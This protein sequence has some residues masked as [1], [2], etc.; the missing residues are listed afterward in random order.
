M[1]YH[2]YGIYVK[3]IKNTISKNTFTKNTIRIVKR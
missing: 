3:G 1:S 2:K